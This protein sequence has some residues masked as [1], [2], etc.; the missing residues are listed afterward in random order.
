MGRGGQGRGWQW[1]HGFGEVME[2]RWGARR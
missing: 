1:R 2:Q